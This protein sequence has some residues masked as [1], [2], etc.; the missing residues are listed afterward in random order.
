VFI[1]LIPTGILALC[2]GYFS[3]E[4][5]KAI[6]V[7]VLLVVI[8]LQTAQISGISN[9]NLFSMRNAGIS[10]RTAFALPFECFGSAYS[11]ISGKREKGKG[12]N[13]GSK[14]LVAALFSLP[15][16]IFLIWIFAKSDAIFESY[17]QSFLSLIRIDAAGIFLDV[18]F[19]GLIALFVFP[20][21]FVLKSGFKLEIKTGKGVKGIDWVYVASFLGICA[22]VYLSY[23]AVQ[24][25]YFFDAA[26]PASHSSN[27]N[28][29]EYAN[30]GFGELCFIIALTFAV[31]MTAV[32]L[33]R[34][35]EKGEIHPIVR[36]V[37]SV[38]SASAL[39]FV[40]SAFF[41]VY[42]YTQTY[43]LTRSRVMGCWFIVTLGLCVLGLIAKIWIKNLN[44]AIIIGTVVVLMTIILNFMNVDYNIAKYNV[45]RYNQTQKL[46]ISY[47]SGLSPDMIPALEGLM[48]TPKKKEALALMCLTYS[49][50][51]GKR[52]GSWTVQ[53]LRA[54]D[55][56]IK[57]GADTLDYSEC[58]SLVHGYRW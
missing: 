52:I 10:L 54:R 5:V 46:D 56:I 18:F 57:Y 6:S 22:L 36:I 1:S 39:I 20:L 35:D 37:L 44:I 55:I 58:D 11:S 42:L 25:T 9:A 23:V 33:T 43:G 28:Y 50:L 8:I 47:L 29:S 38:L 32:H 7:P 14:V 53:E 24:F 17:V 26:L 2:F 16:V 41:R 49:N 34:K 3:S 15:A 40:A 19:G 13:T 45:A 48:D 4:P 30:R 21:V 27:I 12:L 31:V 51:E